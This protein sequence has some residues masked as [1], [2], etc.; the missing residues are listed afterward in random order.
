MVEGE[1]RVFSRELTKMQ[2]AG[3]LLHG[4]SMG[5]DDEFSEQGQDVRKGRCGQ[6]SCSSCLSNMH[7]NPSLIPSMT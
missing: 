1:A 3:G 6:L 4:I 5:R 7:R 2:R